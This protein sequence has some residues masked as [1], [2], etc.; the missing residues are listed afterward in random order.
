[1]NE[2]MNEWHKA[3]KLVYFILKIWIEE[4]I[5]KGGGTWSPLS[6]VSEVV[7]WLYDDLGDVESNESE[8]ENVFESACANDVDDSD[9]SRRVVVDSELEAD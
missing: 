9:S 8:S 5:K 4:Y 3:K 2:W 7:S 6:R 1:M